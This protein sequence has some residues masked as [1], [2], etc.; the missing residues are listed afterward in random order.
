MKAARTGASLLLIWR[1]R[2]T[3][4][5]SY[6]AR[7]DEKPAVGTIQDDD[8]EP[9]EIAGFKVDKFASP[10]GAGF[11]RYP[12]WGSLRRMSDHVISGPIIW[13]TQR[14]YPGQREFAR[15]QHFAGVAH[16]LAVEAPRVH[17]TVRLPP[18]RRFGRQQRSSG[19]LHIER[20]E[21]HWNSFP[22]CS[23]VRSSGL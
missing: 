2:T 4:L 12:L 19:C 1:A 10:F 5:N 16:L 7:Q 14:R 11:D 22:E 17:F 13:N 23:F 6:L 21:A 3:Q 18:I 9:I 8:G 15:D 20:S